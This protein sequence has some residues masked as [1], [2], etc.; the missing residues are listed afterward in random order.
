LYLGDQYN[1]ILISVGT[2]KEEIEIE[3]QIA[4]SINSCFSWTSDINKARFNEAAITLLR[5]NQVRLVAISLSNKLPNVIH[6]QILVKLQ[7]FYSSRKIV[8]ENVV[9]L[10]TTWPSE[11][12]SNLINSNNIA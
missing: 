11:R 10:L 7:S 6:R 1:P 5:S 8:V 3:K 4:Y 9:Y 2:R 12:K